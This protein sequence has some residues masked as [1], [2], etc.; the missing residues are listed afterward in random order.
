MVP[1][2]A[3]PRTAPSQSAARAP[4]PAR[5]ASVTRRSEGLSQAVG[6]ASCAYTYLE[7][8]VEE[9]SVIGVWVGLSAEGE[10]P[11]LALTFQI[12]IS[13][14]DGDLA[15]F[16]CRFRQLFVSSVCTCANAIRVALKSTHRQNAMFSTAY[17]VSARNGVGTIPWHRP[18]DA[19][20]KRR[21][22]AM[23]RPDVKE[24]RNWP[25]RTWFQKR[26]TAVRARRQE[27]LQRHASPH[28]P[29][30]EDAEPRDRDEPDDH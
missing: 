14:F 3:S 15:S 26:L 16:T 4:I 11:T 18:C 13:P 29:T 9:G 25:Q 5:P 27:I 22:L 8:H 21:A 7:S 10:H 12:V 23:K 6:S 24:S 28:D 17:P 30:P 19:T 1:P 2:T 20:L